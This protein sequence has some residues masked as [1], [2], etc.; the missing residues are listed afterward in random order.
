MK[1]GTVLTAI[2]VYSYNTDGT[3]GAKMRN[4]V[5]EKVMSHDFALQMHGFFAEPEERSIRFDVVLS[6]DVAPHEAVKTLTDEI[7][8]MYPDFTVSI[9]P[10]VDLS[11]I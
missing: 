10:D 2:G 3:E 4:A 1:T 9:T 6:F 5:M 11:D 8:A 7:K